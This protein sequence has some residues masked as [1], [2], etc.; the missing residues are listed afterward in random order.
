MKH[1]FS[2]KLGVN[3][4]HVATLRQARGEKFPDPAQAAVHAQ[5]CGADGITVH[6]REDR[7][8]IQDSDL[9][10][11]R[12]VCRLPINL[13]MALHPG[14]LRVAL[15]FRPEKV[16]IVP[17]RRQEITTEG[18]LNVIVNA[19]KLRNAIRQLRAKKIQVSLFVDPALDQIK[20]AFELRADAVEIHTGAYANAAGSK[21][22]KELERIRQAAALA[23]KF[24]LKVHAGHG[25]DYQNTRAVARIP[26]IE[27]FNIGF[28]IVSRAIFTGIGPAVS[29]MK[30]VIT[31]V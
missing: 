23:A 11:I 9:P 14:I 19:K 1:S 21:K 13:E 24:S 17:E 5:R 26:E 15:Q 28:S 31:S 16:C 3:I 22:K 20:K 2:K 7:R 30:K 4:D 18:G 27:E 12:K 6:L 8:H 25:L 10:A 29:E